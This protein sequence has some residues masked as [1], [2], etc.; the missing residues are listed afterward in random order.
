MSEITEGVV[1]FLHTEKMDGFADHVESLETQL[2]TQTERVRELEEALREIGS[3]YTTPVGAGN[4][5]E[6]RK[7]VNKALL[8]TGENG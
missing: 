1:R 6:I 5:F 3:H 4:N 8:P 2:S 7:I